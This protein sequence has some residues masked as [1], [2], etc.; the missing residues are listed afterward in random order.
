MPDYL[1]QKR[2]KNNG[3]LDRIIVEG[4]HQ[5][6]VTKEEFERV[7]RMLEEKNAQTAQWRKNK[8][9]YSD[10]LWRRKLRCQCGHA[11]AKTRWHSKSRDFTTYT[12][13]CYDQTRTGTVPAR[14]K[15]GLSIEGVCRVPL[16]QDWKIHTMA[17]KVLHAVF[18]DPEGTLLDAAAVLGCSIAGVEQ[19]EVLRDKE[20][21][22]EQLKKERGRY[23]TL[24][25][26]R[27]NNEIPK[28]VFSRKQQEVGERIAEL[29]QRMA[30]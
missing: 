7:Q 17:Q 3:E 23:E 6:I 25:D 20:I 18:D 11:F 24:L 30:Q 29:E 16:V 13:K 15:N 14:L 28:E 26:M 12:Y 22:E 4:K 21:I 2:A 19:S 1:E 9:V 27:M 5:P 10:D 8:G